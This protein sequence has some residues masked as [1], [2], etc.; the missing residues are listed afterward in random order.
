MI[1]DQKILARL[2]AI[3]R[4]LFEAKQSKKLSFEQLGSKMGRNEVWVASLFYGQAKPAAEDIKSLSEALD[5]KKELLEESIGDGYFPNKCDLLE[6]PPR[7]PVHYR[8][9][10]M[11]LAYAP[12]FKSIINEKFGDGIMS[13]I[14]YDAKIEKETVDGADWVKITQRGKFLPYKRF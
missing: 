12:A 6:M 10:E 1:I 5:I 14:A 2:P 8:L 13:A 7:D 3:S 11:V 4:T 9:V